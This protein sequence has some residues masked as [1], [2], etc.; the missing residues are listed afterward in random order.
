MHGR[1]WQRGL[2]WIREFEAWVRP[3]LRQE[4]QETAKRKVTRT[5]QELLKDNELCVLFIR[6]LFK[7]KVNFSVPR[8]CRRHLSGARTRLGLPSLNED[9]EL[10]D[11]IRGYE[12]SMPRTVVQALSLLV[13]DVQRIAT[14]WGGSNDWWKVNVA[15]LIAVGFICILRGIEVRRIKIEGIRLVLKNGGEVS[16][17][18]VP[19][20]PRLQSIEG[21]FVHL[22]WRKSQQA[23]DVWVPLACRSTLGLLLKQLQMLRSVGRTAGPLFPSRTRC[24]GGRSKCNCIGQRA[25]IEGLRN[26]L[27]EVCGMTKEQSLLYKGHSL[28]VGGS[29]HMRLLGVD[30]E[31]HRLMGGWASLVSS[32]G[33]FQLG[34]DEQL[35]I[36]EK[37]AL[38]ERVSP[39][40]GGG[41]PVSLRD[42]T[43][44]TIQS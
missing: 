12:R 24:G 2:R 21:A 27:R 9:I 10:C 15:T 14:Q 32:R 41:R 16:A 6:S 43:R 42:M 18:D 38:K 1:Y 44:M 40:A 8:A 35:K 22:V 29:N 11:L 20:L 5:T 34:T 30:D 7:R 19:V 26:A 13:D 3:F 25:M 4:A 39:Q 17:E 23:H 33:Y 36:A 31:V 28:R 37:F